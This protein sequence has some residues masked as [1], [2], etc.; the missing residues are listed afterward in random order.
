MEVTHCTGC[1]CCAKNRFD[2]YGPRSRVICK[3]IHS[4]GQNHF[5]A[6]KALVNILEQITLE[7]PCNACDKTHPTAPSAVC[8]WVQVEIVPVGILIFRLVYHV[9]THISSFVL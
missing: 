7:I 8:V 4:L 6:L 1:G 5:L 3:V 2:K 9:D